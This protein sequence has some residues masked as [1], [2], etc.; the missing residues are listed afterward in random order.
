MSTNP[1][2]SPN[3]AETSD[4]EFTVDLTDVQNNFLIPPGKYP[5]KVIGVDQKVSKQGNPMYVFSFAIM[6]G[7]YAGW[8][9]KTFCAITPAAMFKIAELLE[10]LKVGAK[11]AVAKFNRD[12]VLN[13][14]AMLDIDDS[15]YLGE[16]R[17]GITKVLEHPDGP[18]CY[19]LS[20]GAIANK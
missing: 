19:N 13:K 6:T 9:F 7:E 8:E 16:M 17:S 5:A 15:E 12:T 20:L 11:G 4:F 1:F 2:G 18:D 10:A 3:A 14:A